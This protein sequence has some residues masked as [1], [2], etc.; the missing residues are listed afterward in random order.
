VGRARRRSRLRGAEP[1]GDLL[2]GADARCER[3]RALLRRTDDRSVGLDTGHLPA[4][5]DPV[6]T[7][8]RVALRAAVCR[9][10]RHAT[11]DARANTTADA[12]ANAQTD[13][14]PDPGADAIRPRGIGRCRCERR[15]LTGNEMRADRR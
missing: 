2:S 1:V 13:A 5:P 14:D 6:G 12:R 7:P 15:P 3:R 11:T 10:N 9:A 8:E 4:V